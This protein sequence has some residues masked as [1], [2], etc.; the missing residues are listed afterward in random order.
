[1]ARWSEAAAMRRRRGSPTGRSSR[2]CGGSWPRVQ[3]L[4]GCRGTGWP[5]PGGC[6]PSWS[7]PI[8]GCPSRGRWTGRGPGARQFFEGVSQ[9]LLAATAGHGGPPGLLVVD[10]LQWADEASLDVL[11]YLVHRLGGGPLLVV[12]GGRSEQVP[13]GARLRRLAADAR[14][15]GR[16]DTLELPPLDAAGVAGVGAARAPARG[17]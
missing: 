4:T 7:R 6:C 11:A 16:G 9:V 17:G 12:A 8:R 3:P 13:A 1:G 2:A 5:R 14:R 15:A 10:D